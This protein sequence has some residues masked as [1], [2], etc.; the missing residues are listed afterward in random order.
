[1]CG[2]QFRGPGAYGI[3]IDARI[4]KTIRFRVVI[5]PREGSLNLVKHCVSELF[6]DME[7]VAA[8]MARIHPECSFTT[9]LGCLANSLIEAGLTYLANEH[10]SQCSVYVAHQ[11]L[12]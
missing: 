7:S 12:D 4:R 3:N 10:R 11:N 8:P 2:V 1:V 6:L 5:N 9:V